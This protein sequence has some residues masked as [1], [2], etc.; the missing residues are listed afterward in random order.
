[1]ESNINLQNNDDDTIDL[2]KYIHLLTKWWWLVIL[3]GLVTGI[4]GYIISKNLTPY[5]ASSATV[6]INQAPATQTTD[7][8]SVMMSERLAKTYAQ[9]MVK[10]SVLDQVIKQL[11]LT[12]TEK[13][14]AGMLQVTSLI[15]T[16][17]IEIKAETPDPNL[18]ASIA[19]SVVDVFKQQIEEIQGSRFKESKD[20]LL[21]QMGELER[22]IKDI[23]TQIKQTTLADEKVKL[24]EKAA[25]YNT[26]YGNLLQS[27]EQIRVS[28]AQAVSSVVQ[29]EA[30]VPELNPVRPKTM[31]NTILAALLGGLLV[32]AII[33]MR[34][35]FDDTIRTTEPITKDFK[36]AVLG[37]IFRYS[38][39]L[40]EDL[41]TLKEP[42]SP[43]SEAYRSIRTSINY[44]SVDKPLQTFMVTSTDPG[45]GKTT[46]LGNLAIVFAQTNKKVLVVDCDLRK[47]RVHTTF[48]CE[49]IVG[50]SNLLTQEDEIPLEEV[51][52]P[53]TQD[54]LKILTSGPILPN[55]SEWLGSNKMKKLLK[56][57]TDYADI[58]ILDTPPTMA[59]TDA[60][61]LAP[62]TDGVVLV[63]RSGR[64][65][66]DA[67]K[68][69]IGQ[70]RAANARILGVVLNDVDASQSAYSYRYGSKGKY[71]AYNEYYG[72]E[73][74]KKKNFLQII[75]H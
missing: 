39:K 37:S 36:L 40:E 66:R 65:H 20:S 34:E 38:T 27:Y 45:E 1:L 61:V 6:L 16:Q 53:S 46:T 43:V 44:S 19:N 71:A 2:R 3:V 17:L 11:N 69:T 51:L 64:T 68:N 54:N 42:R 21:A 48:G 49:N 5:Y 4:L 26:I 47:P 72:T 18:S 58:V 10:G 50:L 29:I 56:A 7:Y 57:M 32:I 22:Q 9:M 23:G 70:F 63:I 28:E 13:E 8:S 14:L 60:A 52:Q 15:N 25:Q 55:P 33:F 12:F 74:K 59:V 73:P 75:W 30:A 67:L 41:I 35:A 31:Q 24:G 62:Q